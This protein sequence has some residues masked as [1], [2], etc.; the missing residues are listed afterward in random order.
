M[1]SS[2][3]VLNVTPTSR[4]TNDERTSRCFAQLSMLIALS[5]VI[6]L[7]TTR[8]RAVALWACLASVSGLVP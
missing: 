3:P 8:L 6:A 7:S 1:V 5:T 2:R 4:P